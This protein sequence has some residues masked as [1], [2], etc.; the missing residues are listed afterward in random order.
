MAVEIHKGSLPHIF[1]VDLKGNGIFTEVA[2]MKKDTLGNTYYFPT[3]ALDNIDKARLH[4]IVTNRNAGS[5]E[6]WDLMSQITLNNGVNAL[7]YFHQL[8][9]VISPSGQIYNPREGIVGGP[10]DGTIDTR[11]PEARAASEA[12]RAAANAAATAAATAAANAAAN[13]AGAGA[14]AT[15]RAATQPAPAP[16]P[17]PAEQP[18]PR[19][20]TTKKRSTKKSSED[21]AGSE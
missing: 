17:E 2:V 18:T 11:S 3:N 21:S 13:V 15:Q 8:V 10:S 14:A 20:K 6:L 5:F 12:A 4:K 19:A 9:R 16:T 7:E 1:W